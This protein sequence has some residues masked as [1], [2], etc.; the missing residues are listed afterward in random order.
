MPPM[1]PIP[2]MPGK[3]PNIVQK[4]VRKRGRAEEKWKG[5]EDVE[6]GVTKN[7]LV[8]KKGEKKQRQK[9]K[10]TRRSMGKVGAAVALSLLKREDGGKLR[11]INC[12]ELPSV[13]NG[14]Q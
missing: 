7:K 4:L 8:S 1:P 14:G 6:D 12:D 5:N 2:S 9:G 3:P 13:T 11:A 10:P